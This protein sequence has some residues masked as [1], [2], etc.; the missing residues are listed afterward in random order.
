M[1]GEGGIKEEE[2]ELEGR[3]EAKAWACKESKQLVE[4][5]GGSNETGDVSV[6]VGV[7]ETTEEARVGMLESRR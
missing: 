7:L 2:L 4:R 1:S 3:N 5:I 6:D